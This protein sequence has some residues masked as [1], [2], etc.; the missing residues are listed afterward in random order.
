MK[1]SPFKVHIKDGTMLH[2]DDII[3]LTNVSAKILPIKDPRSSICRKL[4]LFVSKKNILFNSRLQPFDWSRNQPVFDSEVERMRLKYARHL[5]SKPCQPSTGSIF[6]SKIHQTS[7]KQK[8]CKQQSHL[9]RKSAMYTKT[10]PVQPTAFIQ[11]VKE[12]G[13]SPIKTETCWKP[14][15][16]LP[17]QSTSFELPSCS[18][19]KPVPKSS[20]NFKPPDYSFE[21]GFDS[22]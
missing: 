14:T 16:Y 9:I 12:T 2:T 21:I 10:I 17:L 3:I 4:M 6:P 1:V 11:S 18:T 19:P 7:N 8:Q 5:V 22:D 15:R 13:L 20:L